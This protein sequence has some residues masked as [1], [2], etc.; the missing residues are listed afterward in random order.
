MVRK[1]LSALARQVRLLA[2][3]AVVTVAGG[4]GWSWL[5]DY[6]DRDA[7]ML[8]MGDISQEGES[9]HGWGDEFLAN[10]HEHVLAGLPIQVAN[11]CGLG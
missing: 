11:A 4:A 7:G 8:G 6:D 1:W 3:L 10:V 2:V 5:V 9:R